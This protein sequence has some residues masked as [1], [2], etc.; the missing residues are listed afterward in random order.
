[1]D[2]TMTDDYKDPD[3]KL[4]EIPGKCLFESA[5]LKVESFCFESGSSYGSVGHFT[6]KHEWQFG[7]DL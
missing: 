4:F 7:S 5:L 6:R 2:S 1:M 3:Q